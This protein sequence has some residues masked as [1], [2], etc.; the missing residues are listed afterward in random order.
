MPYNTKYSE[1]RYIEIQRY[2]DQLEE[3]E[4]D[5]VITVPIESADEAKRL[6][7]LFFDYFNITGMKGAF[8]I[9]TLNNLLIVGKN[10]ATLS[11]VVPIRKSGALPRQI[12]SLIQKILMS[13]NPNERIKQLVDDETISHGALSIVLGELGRVLGE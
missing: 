6:R 1:E 3:L 9:S 11:N 2:L 13:E 7:W 12:D 10:K 4:E 5:K 8:K